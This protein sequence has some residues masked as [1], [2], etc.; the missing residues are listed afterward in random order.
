[1]KHYSER[2]H[3][4]I[5]PLVAAA[6]LGGAF[7]LIAVPFSVTA[8]IIITIILAVATPLV[9][10]FSSPLITVRDGGD[11]P[12]GTELTFSHAHIDLGWLGSPAILSETD[13][14]NRLGIESSDH[15]FVGHSPFVKTAISLDNKDPDDAI[16]TWIVTTRAPEKLASVIQEAHSAQ[17]S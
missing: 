11:G 1:M 17:T 4:G 10:W 14:H 13:L 5:W 12:L 3:P 2:L 8:A 7:G 9:L 16:D 6:G 15:D